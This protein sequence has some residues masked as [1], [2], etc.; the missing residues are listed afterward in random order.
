VAGADGVMI[1]TPLAQTEE[2]PG[3]GFNWGMAAPHA[4]LPRGTRI[5]VGIKGTLKQV[6]F[7]P[8][9]LSDGTQNL[10]GALKACMG[11]CGA[12]NIQ[13]LHQADMIVA[14]SIRTEGKIFQMTGRL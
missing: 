9:S 4:N 14:P 11:M 1:G 3:K 7:G 8:T 12:L 5:N 13:E 2:A 10:V 6:L